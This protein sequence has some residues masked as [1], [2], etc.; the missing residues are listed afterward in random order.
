MVV[1]QKTVIFQEVT[2]SWQS[3]L[4]YN[5]R[6]KGQWCVIAIIEGGRKEGTG[7]RKYVTTK[8]RRVWFRW[9]TISRRA[10]G[11]VEQM[12]FRLYLRE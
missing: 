12:R 8:E 10:R 2:E 4:R 3:V 11:K 9:C 6:E 1:G 7:V 5:R